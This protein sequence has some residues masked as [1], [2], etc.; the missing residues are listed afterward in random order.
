MKKKILSVL[1]AAAM[2]VTTFSV[3]TYAGAINVF[4]EDEEDEDEDLAEINIALMC[5]APMDQSVTDPIVDAVNADITVWSRA[6]LPELDD[7]NIGLAGSPTKIAKA[8]DKVRKG[9]GEKVEMDPKEADGAARDRWIRIL[10]S[11]LILLKIHPAIRHLDTISF[12]KFSLLSG[13]SE[14]KFPG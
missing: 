10:W 9:A 7:A 13:T 12:K 8:S 3:C 5:F 11:P 4:A 14:S 6:D 1:L 2:T